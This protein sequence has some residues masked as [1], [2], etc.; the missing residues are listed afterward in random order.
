MTSCINR[1]LPVTILSK[2]GIF[3]K[4]KKQSQRRIG[5]FNLS[6]QKLPKITTKAPHLPTHKTNQI[7]GKLTQIV[8]FILL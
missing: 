8:F 3:Y 4:A 5:N 2:R 6:L 1:D 7:I